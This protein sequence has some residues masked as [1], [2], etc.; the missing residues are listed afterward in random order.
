MAA[1]V[2]NRLVLGSSPVEP[3]SG[4]STIDVDDILDTNKR[5]RPSKSELRNTAESE[6]HHVRGIRKCP[7]SYKKLFSCTP[8]QL[9]C[10][11]L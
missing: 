5:L 6:D 10:P 7:Q 2:K 3:E 8:I 9:F 11:T 4:S 1:D